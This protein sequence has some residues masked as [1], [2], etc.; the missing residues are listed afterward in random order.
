MTTNEVID[1]LLKIV[2]EYKKKQRRRKF[3]KSTQAFVLHYQNQRC[4]L[5][6]MY[7]DVWEFDHID[8]DR[9]NN[10]S[11]NCQALCPNCHA[12][13]TKRQKMGFSF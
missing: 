2:K 1:Y 3:S 6:L 5:C 9:T 12:R 7:L 8:G 4:R 11:E 13:K 10:S